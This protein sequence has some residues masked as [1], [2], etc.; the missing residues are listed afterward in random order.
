MK[1]GIESVYIAAVADSQAGVETVE[2]DPGSDPIERIDPIKTSNKKLSVGILLCTHTTH[3]C[4][5]ICNRRLVIIMC[6]MR[7]YDF[8]STTLCLKTENSVVRQQ[9]SC[10]ELNCV[11]QCAC[12]SSFTLHYSRFR[13]LLREHQATLRST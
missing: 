6:F 10:D 7:Q 2:C 9:Q 5:Y 12:L 13:F 4:M 3:L 11:T 1:C 8:P